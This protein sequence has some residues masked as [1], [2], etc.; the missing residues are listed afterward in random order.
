MFA[1]LLAGAALAVA[2]AL[3][4]GVAGARPAVSKA[5]FIRKGDAICAAYR[6][7]F[8]RVP[9]S[10]TQESLRANGPAV[11]RI[12]RAK[13][14]ALRALHPPRSARTVLALFEQK[15]D[16]FAEDIAAARAGTFDPSASRVDAISAR[17]ARE[18]HAYGFQV[19]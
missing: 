3:A 1:R 11:L 9:V 18:T 16:A 7:R 19:C 15:A 10:P 2:V 4:P 5:Q 17:L 12:A 6:V 13:I 14:A 8:M